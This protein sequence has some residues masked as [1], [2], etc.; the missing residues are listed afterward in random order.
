MKAVVNQIQQ[1][2]KSYGNTPTELLIKLEFGAKRIEFKKQ[3]VNTINRRN[4]L[5]IVVILFLSI[6]N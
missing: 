6:Y 2:I 4:C 1:L 3:Y 5:F